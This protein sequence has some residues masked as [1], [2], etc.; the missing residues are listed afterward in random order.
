[1]P[2]VQQWRFVGELYNTYILIEQGEDAFLIDKHA[3]HERILFEKLK[4]NPE[5]I[6]SQALLTPIPCR[7]NPEDVS[8]LLN[9]N[10]L[11]IAASR[12]IS[13]VLAWR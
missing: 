1:M 7:L 4:E 11:L 8:M 12:T 2:E 3:A 10:P 5:S 9:N 13:S 6:S